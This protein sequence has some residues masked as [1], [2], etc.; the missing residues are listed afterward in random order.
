VYDEKTGEKLAELPIDTN[1][2]AKVK[3]DDLAPVANAAELNQRLVASGKVEGCMA[4]RYFEFT[5]RRAVSDA[6]LDT[7]VVQDLAAGLKDPAVGLAGAFQR[8]AQY[9]SFFQR[10]VGPQ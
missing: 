7:C 2:V 9:S 1:A 5:A 4:Q 6:T 8:M 10:K 3:P